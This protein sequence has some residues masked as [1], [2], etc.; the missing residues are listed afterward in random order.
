MIRPQWEWVLDDAEGR[1]L[2]RPISPVFANQ[3]DAEQWLGE[4]WRELARQEVAVA[5][6]IH[7][8]AQAAA[9]VALRI[10]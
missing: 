9:A 8:G 1:V 6:L 5:R 4:N 3:F 10:P 7:D 2:D